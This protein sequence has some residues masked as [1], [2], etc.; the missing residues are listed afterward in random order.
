MADNPL[1]SAVPSR[2]TRYVV[3]PENLLLADVLDF[4]PDQGII[5]LREQRVV[6]V[7]ATA[8]GLLRKALID[9][10]RK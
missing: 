1:I 3:D 6:I 7:S 4:R 9:A 2:V 5:R 8:M 10:Y